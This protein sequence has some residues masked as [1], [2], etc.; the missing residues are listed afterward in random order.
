[1]ADLKAF[2]MPASEARRLMEEDARKVN[3]MLQSLHPAGAA[4]AMADGGLFEEG[5]LGLLEPEEALRLFSEMGSA[6]AGQRR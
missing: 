3:E 5:L 6:A 2:L 1:M 4:L